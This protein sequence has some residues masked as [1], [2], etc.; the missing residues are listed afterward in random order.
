VY[1]FFGQALIFLITTIINLYFFIVLLRF[2]F[3][4]FHIYNINSFFSFILNATYPIW[5]SFYK[6]L[7]KY[8]R[9]DL[10]AATILL[11]LKSLE[12]LLVS[13][14]SR[15]ILPGLMSL[16]IWPIGESI[17]QI[18]NVL[19]FAVLLV[20]LLSWFQ[21]RLHSPLTDVLIKMTE[22]LMTPMRRLVPSGQGIDFSPL[23]VLIIL[24][25]IDILLAHPI[26]QLGVSLSFQ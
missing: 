5:I 4:F 23:L 12:F 20:A 15:G 26:M 10:S 18:I 22:P 7:L 1:S 25:L 24:K 2:L 14:I 13:L 16:I 6:F 8:S 3:I 19:F 9:L 11:S 21:P 17:S